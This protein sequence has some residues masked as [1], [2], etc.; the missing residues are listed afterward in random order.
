MILSERKKMPPE[1]NLS[2]MEVESDPKGLSPERSRL[3][4]L[5]D[6]AGVFSR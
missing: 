2:S 5:K 4:D 1:F 3:V 6:Q